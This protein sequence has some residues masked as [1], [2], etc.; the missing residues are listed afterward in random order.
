[1]ELRRVSVDESPRE[2]GWVRLLAE[3]SYGNDNGRAESYWLEVPESEAGA[4]STSGDP[5]LVWLTP[6]AATVGEV[7]RV[8]VPCDPALL[9]AMREILN[10]WTAWYPDLMDVTLT[11][12]AEVRAKEHPDGRRRTASFFSGGIDSFFTALTHDMRDGV[13]ETFLIDDHL[14][15][16]GFDIPLS[17]GSAFARVSAT[18]GQVAKAMGRRV[19]PVVTNLRETRFREADWSLVSHG[20]ALAGVA[21]ALAGTY[22]RVLIPSGAGYHDLEPWGSHPLTDAMMS[23][24]RVR[25]VHD[26]SAFTRVQKT[27]Y[28]AR[29]PLVGRHLR[30]CHRDS[31]GGNC[32]RCNKCYRTMLAL[33][34]LGALEQSEAFDRRWLDIRR[35]ERIY[36]PNAYDVR[37]FRSIVELARTVGRTDIARAVERTLRH[38]ARRKRWVER[39]RGLRSTPVAWRWAPAWERRLLKGW[40]T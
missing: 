38:S 5:W 32:G 21:H 27:E 36:C 40:I 35:A 1:M 31:S 11:A 14:L 18:V 4:L 34:A 39:V 37:E 13:A 3:V 2:R 16:W 29:H 12:P 25:I 6:L 9:G 26:G 10:V 15:V 19:V 33:E 24:S 8:H 20:P 23:S 28:L 30:V 7:L 17:N 22:G